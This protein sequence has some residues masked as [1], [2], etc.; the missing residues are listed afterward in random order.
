MTISGNR[1]KPCQ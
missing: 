1:Q